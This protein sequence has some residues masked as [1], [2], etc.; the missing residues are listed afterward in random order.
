M[1]TEYEHRV[2]VV[3]QSAVTAAG[4][5]EGSRLIWQLMVVLPSPAWAEMLKKL[6]PMSNCA[7]VRVYTLVNEEGARTK[8]RVLQ[9]ASVSF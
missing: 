1:A 4:C 9:D 5:I 6:E 3:D 8:K 7:C 2:F